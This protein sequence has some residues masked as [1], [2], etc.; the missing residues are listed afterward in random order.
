[1]TTPIWRALAIATLL[2]L[3]AFVTGGPARSALILE[4][5]PVFGPNSLV[6]DTSTGL[7]WLNLGFSANLSPVEVLAQLQP[8]K[9]FSGFRYTTY[10][11][12]GSLTSSFFSPQTPCCF[13]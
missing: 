9:K 2:L 11:E 7:E 6:L 3:G 10:S 4:N 13:N 5:D 12:F 1:M 8:G